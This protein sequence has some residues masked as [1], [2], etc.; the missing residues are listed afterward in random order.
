ML[1]R[2]VNH[3]D[4]ALKSVQCRD[5]GEIQQLCAQLIT[6]CLPM[7]FPREQSLFVQ[8]H[9]QAM[10]PSNVSKQCVQAMFSSNVFKQYVQ[11][12]L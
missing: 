4:R 9:V 10:C 3:T 7:C 12:L 6:G 11:A 2:Q 1:D 5:F 8:C